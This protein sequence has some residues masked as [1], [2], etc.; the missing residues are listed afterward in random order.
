MSSPDDTKLQNTSFDCLFSLL[1]DYY[2]ITDLP[3]SV[4]PTWTFFAVINAIASPAMTVINF[5]I[6]WTI[7]SDKE[8]RE[9]THNILLAALALTDFLQGLIVEPMFSWFLV[10]LV[11]RR[12]LSCHFVVF[13]IPAAI[14]G[15][16]T[17]N[18]LTLASLDLFVAIEYPLFYRKHVTTKK[19]V[20]GT[21]VFWIANVSILIVGGVLVESHEHLQGIPNAV[22]MA[23]NNLIILYCTVKVQ[24]TAY[25]QRRAIN[26]QVQA[27]QQETNT[28]EDNRRREQFK[29]AMT[30]VLI[31]LSTFLFYCPYIINSILLSTKGKNF[32]DDFKFIYFAIDLTFIH[33]QSLVN[34]IVISLRLSY[35]R[36]G[37]KNKIR[38]RTVINSINFG[39]T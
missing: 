12:P 14:L 3:D 32:T 34:P 4:E 17:L 6:I 20:I 30:M 19:V 8:L 27:V 38:C 18:T 13:G 36:E 28:D 9:D 11:K 35:I 15:C 24:I 10:A 31:V 39:Q 37:V 16:W 26:A 25:R 29:Q 1:F 21:G 2:N 7:L 23:V 5:L 33:F 22:V